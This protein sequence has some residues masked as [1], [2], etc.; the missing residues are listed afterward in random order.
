[1]DLFSIAFPSGLGISESRETGMWGP[2]LQFSQKDSQIPSLFYNKNEKLARIV[3]FLMVTGSNA[4]MNTRLRERLPSTSNEE[5]FRVVEANVVKQKTKSYIRGKLQ[6]QR[7]YREPQR[8]QPYKFK[9][10]FHQ[11]VYFIVLFLVSFQPS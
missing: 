7:S 8:N 5:V 1:M 9:T 3:D 11:R 4:R 2:P 10:Y 6:L